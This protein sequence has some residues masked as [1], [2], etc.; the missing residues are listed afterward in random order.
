[1]RSYLNQEFSRVKADE[2]NKH[3]AEIGHYGQTLIIV[4]LHPHNYNIRYRQLS[5]GRAGQLS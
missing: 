5:H 2:R 1:M 4:N 3:N